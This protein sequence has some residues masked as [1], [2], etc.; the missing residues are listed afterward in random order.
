MTQRRILFITRNFPPLT[1][2]MERLCFN[3]YTMLS[4]DYEVILIAPAGAERPTRDDSPL[5]TV[6]LKP[7]SVF[8]LLCP[9]QTLFACLRYRPQLILAG[10]GLTALSAQLA[11]LLCNKPT[12]CL[13]HGL[14]VIANNAVYQK[15]FVPAIRRCSRIIA[16][17]ANTAQLAIN[18]GVNPERIQIIHPGVA[19]QTASPP[20]ENSSFAGIDLRTR[21]VMLS[22]GRLTPRKGLFEFIERCLPQIVREIPDALLVI[23]GDEAT[24]AV[25]KQAGIKAQLMNLIEQRDLGDYVRF[26]G[27][28]DDPTL[29]HLYALSRV[30]VFPVLT[31]PSDVEGFGMVAVEAAAHGRPTVAFNT[32]GV[33]D[34]VKEHHSGYLIA[35]GDY[36]A[37]SRK[38]IELL[39]APT[40]PL[41]EQRCRAFARQFSWANYYQKLNDLIQQFE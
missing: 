12:V 17:S 1:G 20:V 31:L 29:T 22:V 26:T 36:R 9:L 27:Y 21:R 40:A 30:M 15:L 4:A 32:G 19:L 33:A 18:N 28:A 5:L 38:T 3:I 41:S 7:L 37:F 2:G 10:S 24:D 34:A 25:Q 14:D 13:I 35:P 23:C 16:N 11:G 8:L 39:A 6:P